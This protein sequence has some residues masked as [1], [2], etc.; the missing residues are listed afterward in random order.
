[1]GLLPGACGSG[2][3]PKPEMRTFHSLSTHLQPVRC[4]QVVIEVEAL[5]SGQALD[6]TGKVRDLSR[7][8]LCTCTCCEAT[9]ILCGMQLA[10][11]RRAAN[12]TALQHAKLRSSSEPLRRLLNY[13][14]TDTG[15]RLTQCHVR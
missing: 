14:L 3:A 9:G 2:E 4:L 10:V 1:M 13:K 8:C 15:V 6:I 7:D 11:V 12:S 5:D